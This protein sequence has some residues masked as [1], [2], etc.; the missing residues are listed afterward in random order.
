M[1]VLRSSKLFEAIHEDQLTV[2]ALRTTE[3]NL[4]AITYT[5]P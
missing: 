2:L 3:V 5:G 1:A 4:E